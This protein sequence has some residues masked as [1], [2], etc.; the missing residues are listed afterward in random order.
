MCLYSI[1]FLKL[2][3]KGTLVNYLRNSRK[4]SVQYVNALLNPYLLGQ[5][6]RKAKTCELEDILDLSQAL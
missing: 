5:K 1:I 3:N 2:L 4:E 6:A